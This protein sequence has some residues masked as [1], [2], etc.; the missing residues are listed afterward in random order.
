MREDEELEEIEEEV[1]EGKTGRR[2]V[3]KNR[4]D[5]RGKMRSE[6]WKV[7]HGWVRNEIEKRKEKD[8]GREVNRD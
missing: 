4:N 2:R 8:T 6:K 5:G 1:M 3:E 7:N